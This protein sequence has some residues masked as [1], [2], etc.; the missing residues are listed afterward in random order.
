M[1][2]FSLLKGGWCCWFCWTLANRVSGYGGWQSIANALDHLTWWFVSNPCSA[3]AEAKLSP[4]W[5]GGGGGGEG[6]HDGSAYD[7]PPSQFNVGT[8]HDV[9]LSIQDAVDHSGLGPYA[10]TP[11]SPERP[12]PT[13][14]GGS[15]LSGFTPTAYW[16]RKGSATHDSL[17][18]WKCLVISVNSFH[19][20]WCVYIFRDQSH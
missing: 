6:E 12:S 15:G 2:P 18:H 3:R 10:P 19:F 14:Q 4:F 16:Y 11:Q 1:V 20:S 5:G 17:L 8:V 7:R 13:R 9:V